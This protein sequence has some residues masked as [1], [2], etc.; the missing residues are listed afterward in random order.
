[1]IFFGHLELICSFNCVNFTL[2]VHYNSKTDHWS[3]PANTLS[4]ES[5]PELFETSS[6]LD[7]SVSSMSRS[8]QGV[9]KAN[10]YAWFSLQSLPKVCL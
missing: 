1:M 7:E 9:K 5:G 3:S 6:R 4:A 10:L 2:Q 8:R